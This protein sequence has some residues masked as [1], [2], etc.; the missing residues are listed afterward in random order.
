MLSASLN[1][2]FLSLN[3]L[4]GTR[5][6]SYDVASYGLSFCAW[7]LEKVVD[8]HTNVY[9]YVKKIDIEDKYNYLYKC[10]S[11]INVH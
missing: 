7:G 11:F 8:M 2:T 4:A 5:N 10:S 3:T 1:K 9:T 6:S